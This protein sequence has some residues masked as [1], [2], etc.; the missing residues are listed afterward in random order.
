MMG[1]WL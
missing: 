1:I